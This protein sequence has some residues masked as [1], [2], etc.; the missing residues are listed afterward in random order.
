MQARKLKF[1]EAVRVSWVDSM[2][3][4]GWNYEPDQVGGVARIQTL[5]YVVNSNKDYLTMT[6]SIGSKGGALDPVSIPWPA[7]VQVDKLGD[8]WN[9]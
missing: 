7:I 3:F 4:G 6:T 2:S 9:R 1:R 8:N 5:G